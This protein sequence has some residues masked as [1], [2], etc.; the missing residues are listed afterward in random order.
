MNLYTFSEYDT[1][2][3]VFADTPEEAITTLK[4]KLECERHDFIP[5]CE[6]IGNKHNSQYYNHIMD[7]YFTRYYSEL[8]TGDEKADDW[9]YE[10]CTF[11]LE[12]C[13]YDI[14]AGIV[15]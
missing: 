12:M 2:M 6:H 10:D 4:E 14:Q 15:I 8:N 13:E 5:K 1:R 3:I 9:L 11:Y 7:I